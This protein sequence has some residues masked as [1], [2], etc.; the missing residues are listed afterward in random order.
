MYKAHM[1]QTPEA[2]DS[3]EILGSIDH[4]LLTPRA[5]SQEL[6][7]LCKVA[8]HLRVASVCLLPYFVQQAS[9]LLRD[10][11]VVVS[12]VVAFPHGA[13]SPLAKLK[14][15]EVALGDGATELD[16]VINVSAALSGDW[17]LVEQEIQQLTDLCHSR[18]A[19][20]K[21]IFENCYLLQEDKVRLCEMC[22]SAGVDWVKTSTGFG[23]PASGP[24]GA[25]PEDVALMRRLCPPSV[26]VKA[27]GGIRT[28]AQVRQFLALG[29]NR[30]GMSQTE[31][32]ARELG[33][34]LADE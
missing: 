22:T 34:T 21:V 20:L 13:T 26:H 10:S 3:R 9:R 33:V 19:K 2:E 8:A 11:P 32:L 7:N 4:S 27:S 24:A 28:L 23:Q 29:A 17:H 16:V 1:R 30:I 18:G 14:E 31:A 6:H 25:T 15:S 5:T 12:T